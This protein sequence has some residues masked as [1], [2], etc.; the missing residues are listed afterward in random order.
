MKMILGCGCKGEEENTFAL[1][2]T[3]HYCIPDLSKLLALII[4]ERG[5]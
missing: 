5:K 3:T 2:S 4:M 1:F